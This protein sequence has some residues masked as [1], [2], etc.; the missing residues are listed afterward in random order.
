MRMSNEDWRV[1][2]T[3]LATSGFC[4]RRGCS[5]D[6]PKNTARRR[7]AIP[8]ARFEQRPGLGVDEDEVEDEDD[9]TLVVVSEVT[10]SSQNR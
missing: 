10:A 7:A 4:A 5:G 6:E 2:T 9:E 1:C 3:V 8:R